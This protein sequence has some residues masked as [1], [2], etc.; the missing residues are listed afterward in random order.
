MTKPFKHIRLTESRTSVPYTYAGGAGSSNHKSPPRPAPA[1]HG[2]KILDRLAKAKAKVETDLVNCPAGS[3]LTF[4]PMEFEQSSHFEM[5]M[6]QLENEKLGIKIVNVRTAGTK[7]QY[8]VALPNDKVAVFEERVRKY[9]TAS[10]STDRPKSENLM[11]GIDDIVPFAWAHYWTDEATLPAV[12]E[13][14]WW[15]VWLQ[16]DSQDSVTVL[17]WFRDVAKSQKIL[18]SD[19]DSSFPERVVVL[20][21]ATLEQWF[22]FPGIIQYLAELRRARIVAGEFLSLTP[23][24]QGELVRDLKRRMIPASLK[25]PAVCVLDTGVNRGHPLL[26]GSL[27]ETDTQAWRLEWGTSDHHGHGTEMAGLALFG[28]ELAASLL[29]KGPLSL[30]HR[31]ES[32]KILPPTGKNEAPDYGPITI[33]AML[34]AEDA[35]PA[36]K[37]VFSMAVTAQGSILGGPSLWSASLDQI[38]SGAIDGTQRLAIVSGGNLL[39]EGMKNYPN[40]NY[41]E[42]IEEPAQSWNALTVGAFTNM[43][44]DGDPAT[45]GYKA[46]AQRGSLGPA[47]RTS[48]TW[49]DTD[50]PY[51]P[52][53]VFEGGNRLVAPNGFITNTDDM[54]L[55]TVSMDPKSDALLAASKDTSAATAIAAWMAAILQAEYPD[56]WPESIRALMVHS[57]EWTEQMRTEFPKAKREERLRVYGMGVPNLQRAR[58]TVESYT[59]MIIEDYIQPYRQEGSKSFSNEMHI[60]RLPIPVEVLQDLGST[61]VRMKVTLSYFIEPNPPRR[62][63]VAQFRYA[64]HGLR[65]SLIRSGESLPVFQDRLTRHDWPED[66]EGKRVRPRKAVGDERAWELGETVT[67]KGSIHSDAWT[68]TAAVLAQSGYVAVYPVTGWWRERMK[69]GVVGKKTRYSLVVSISTEAKDVELY[70]GVMNQIAIEIKVPAIISISTA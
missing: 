12:D 56:Y 5:M 6:T 43:V 26:E 32:V 46:L 61:P 13:L 11:T 23:E 68:G 64:S 31:L 49:S 25:S 52:D 66:D 1:Q 22:A 69:L 4:V 37:R 29:Q 53:V 42:S 2:E 3:G 7:T 16:T 55:L 14:F 41:T 50:W 30:V 59:T 18:V 9:M 36:R 40:E 19:H 63:Y 65:F 45:V 47:S 38:T 70:S 10:S 24:F 28:D 58:D 20:A 35:N 44:W 48:L 67:T 27:N 39:E 17:K 21:F 54:S 57:A 15:E 34:I 8:T 60:H 33:G 51:K 62:G